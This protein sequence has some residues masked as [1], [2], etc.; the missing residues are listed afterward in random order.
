M[1]GFSFNEN[2]PHGMP[3]FNIDL[4]FAIEISLLLPKT[5]KQLHYKAQTVFVG[6]AKYWH[7]IITIN[8][9]KSSGYI[10]TASSQI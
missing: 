7:I 3:Y 4:H 1:C 8:L 9:Y 5:Y 10:S 6:Q 2:Y